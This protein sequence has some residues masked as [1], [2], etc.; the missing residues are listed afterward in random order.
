MVLVGGDDAVEVRIG[1]LQGEEV[2]VGEER[3][4]GILEFN[5]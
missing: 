5:W 4:D 1:V 3:D 2:G